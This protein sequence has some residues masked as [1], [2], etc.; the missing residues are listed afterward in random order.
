ML[1]RREGLCGGNYDKG[2]LAV[3]TVA[4]LFVTNCVPKKSAVK[5]RDGEAFSEHFESPSVRQSLEDQ[6]NAMFAK[7]MVE[8]D[9]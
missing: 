5:S 9:E 8:G 4:G 1:A 6:T 7:M 2:K 3:G